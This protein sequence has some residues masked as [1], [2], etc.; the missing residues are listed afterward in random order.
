[1]ADEFDLPEIEL[2]TY[3]HYKGN[4]YEVVGVGRHTEVDEYFVVYKPTVQKPGVPALWI[5]P[6]TMFIETIEK[7]GKVI[8]RFQ[9]IN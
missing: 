5:R 1:M 6:Y 4:E 2:G 9:K 8:P 7:D 3:R